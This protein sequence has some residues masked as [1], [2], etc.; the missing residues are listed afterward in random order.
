MSAV[1]E[2]GPLRAEPPI[3]HTVEEAAG[4]LRIGRTLAY[5][6][7]RRYEDTD[8]R[9]GLP[10]VRLGN[11][12]R[13]PRWALIELACH[14]CVVPLRDLE[15]IRPR[16]DDN[17]DDPETAE[18]VVQADSSTGPGVSGRP[19]QRSLRLVAVHDDRP[20]R[21]RSGRTRRFRA[22]EQLSLRFPSD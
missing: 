11:C 21:D 13:V 16:E 1:G 20:Q 19:T 2:P 9:E 10:V 12:M 8:G 3:L 15:V 4:L 14:G 17:D 7:A 5:V 18:R 22:V 6:M